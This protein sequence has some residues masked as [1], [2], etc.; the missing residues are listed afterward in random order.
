MMM[1]PQNNIPEIEI[2]D[3][4]KSD[5]VNPPSTL[6]FNEPPQPNSAG[7]I[8]LR[9]LMS[10]LFLVIVFASRLISTVQTNQ[11]VQSQTVKKDLFWVTIPG[12]WQVLNEADL[13][14]EYDGFCGGG[15]LECV[16]VAESRADNVT[17]IF[18]H[19]A[20]LLYLFQSEAQIAQDIMDRMRNEDVA[21]ISKRA[22]RIDAVPAYQIITLMPTGDIW[23]YSMIKDTSKSIILITV[24]AGNQEDYVQTKEE[25][26]TIIDSIRWVDAD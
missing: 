24:V 20:D 14:T 13:P 17:I 4:P 11:P 7:Q 9:K 10:A 12:K 16:F 22:M 21:I 2:V 3:R 6:T 8:D 23:A 1:F 18:A 5:Q 15:N 19:R 26:T 25:I